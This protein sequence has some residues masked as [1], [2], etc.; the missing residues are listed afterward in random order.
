MT[1]ASRCVRFRDGKLVLC[2]CVV[3]E[4]ERVNR[5]G[6]KSALIDFYVARVRSPRRT[7]TIWSTSRVLLRP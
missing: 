1:C 6:K 2:A 3:P 5:V 4:K 7:M